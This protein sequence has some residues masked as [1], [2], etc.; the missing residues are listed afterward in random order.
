MFFKFSPVWSLCEKEY[1]PQPQHRQEVSPASSRASPIP[2]AN[3]ARWSRAPFAI[4]R[5]GLPQILMW[6]VNM[7]A[8]GDHWISVE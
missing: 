8:F 6:L 2:S 3:G 1:Y 5:R 4:P 7:K